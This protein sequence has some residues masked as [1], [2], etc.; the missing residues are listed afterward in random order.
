MHMLV[1]LALAAAAP[2]AAPPP[3]W[4][5]LVGDEG[6]RTHYDP[7]SVRS[8]GEGLMRVH[9][10]SDFREPL[11]DA[12]R[13]DVELV[14]DCRAHTSA[15]LSARMLDRAGAVVGARETPLAEARFE[16]IEDATIESRLQDIVCRTVV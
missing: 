4:T 1:S 2:L 11:H 16:P 3:G 15:F 9:V 5:L 13:F 8:A 14:V 6:A 12:T 10:L 7:A